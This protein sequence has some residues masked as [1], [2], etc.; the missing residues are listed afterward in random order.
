[1]KKILIVEDEENQRL[2]YKTELEEEGYIVFVASNGL[3]GL[4]KFEIVHPDIV[5]IDIKMPD[6]D[7]IELLQRIREIDKNI[8][9]IMLTAYG[10]YSQ[11]FTTWA[12]DKYVVKSSDLTKI[13][14]EIR[15]LLKEKEGE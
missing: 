1:M 7:G 13:K 8:P 2:L 11:D 15:N 6:M 9:V 14:N 5:T 12:A 10:E 4:K 3:E